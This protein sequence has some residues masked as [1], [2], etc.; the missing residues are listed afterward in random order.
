MKD[1]DDAVGA[2]AY[3]LYKRDKIAF[4]EA[5]FSTHAR[6]PTPDELKV[7]HTQTCLPAKIGTYR[8]QAEQLAEAFLNAG[9]A[10]RVQDFEDEIR[11]S[12]LNQNVSA[13]LAELKSKKGLGAWAGD[14][15]GNLGVN[16]L[17]IFVIGAVFGGFQALAKFN[18]NMERLFNAPVAAEPPAPVVTQPTAPAV[19][20]P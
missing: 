17:T 19:N 5:T 18:A 6:V 10:K 11:E 1:P 2:I 4:I 20:K 14:V 13:V 12:V 8:A 7:F 9:V 15:V 16:I 3:V